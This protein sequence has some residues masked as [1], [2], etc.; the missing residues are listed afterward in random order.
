MNWKSVIIG[1]SV[2]V[3]FSLL[4]L[5]GVFGN[6]EYQIYDFFLRFRPDRYKNREVV[7]LDVDD[8]AIAYN[9][10]FPWPRSVTADGLLRL[11]EYGAQAAIF[12]IEFI[13]KG[14]QGVDTVYLNQGL[15]ADFNRSFSEISSAARDIF[16]ALKSGR[17]RLADIDE[18]ALAFT[19]LVGG[20]QESLFTK[21]QGVARDN[22]QY[23]IQS[24]AL[25]G[26]SWSTLNLRPDELSGEQA[27][28]RF[29]AEERFSYPVKA[30]ENIFKGKNINIL[31]AL[32]GFSMAA[33]GAG[34][35]NVEIDKDGTRRRLYLAQNIH[36]H[37][38]LQLA[39]APLVNYL[40]NPDLEL[41]NHKMIIRNAK[42]PGGT[43]KDITVPLDGSGRMML[44]WPKEDYFESYH[45]ISFV[46]VSILEDIEVELEQYSMAF[47]TVDISFFS[48][49]EQSLR[50]IPII[51]RDL[52]DLFDA[53]REAKARAL[54]LCSD[55]YFADYVNYR[56][57]SRDLIREIL[58]IRPDEIINEMAP[59]LIG[60]YPE[61]AEAI[62]DEA[63]Y[64]EILTRYLRI[65]L[66]RY[67][68]ISERTERVVKDKF[69][70]LGRVDTGTTDIGANPFWG[71]YVNVGTHGVVLDMIL[72]E[73]FVTPVGIQWQILFALIFVF[74]FFL[75]SGKLTPVPRAISGF[76]MI[77]FIVSVTALLFR[78]T[79]VFFDPLVTVM[80]MTGAVI[81]REIISYAGSE[82]EKQFIRKAFSTYVST[83]VVKEL[84]ADPSRLQLG[85]T[86]RHMSA[87]FTD[88]QG[89]STISEQLD[90]EKLVS[91]LNRYLTFM[92]DA[93][94]EQM[95]TIDKYEGDAIIAFFGA[96]VDLP[97][98]A[99]R[100]CE[101]AISM[102]QIEL[103][104]NKKIMEDNLSPSPLLTRIGINTGPMVAGNMGTKNKMDYTIMGNAVNLAA[105]LEGVNKQYGTWI[106]A[107]DD[108]IRET[109][110]RFLTRKLDR[111][112]VVGINE[113]VRIHEVL[114]IM[115]YASPEQNNLVEVF[116]Q[117][118]DFYEKRKWKEAIEGFKESLSIEGAGPS[119][120]YLHRCEHFLA[121]PPPDTWDGVNN[122]TE[123]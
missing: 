99:I 38:Y 86:K 91:L 118:L 123:K 122:L 22:D 3:F 101:S 108:T 12:D 84:L 65:D 82:Q 1:V 110:G 25:F 6:L 95:G 66:D 88:V 100:A 24:S 111:I 109:E 94:L 58:D 28:R 36:N 15:P 9:G 61:S 16:S 73:S 19:G 13:D 34:F 119:K 17:I 115:D 80:S 87:I 62:L 41:D 96:P 120:R 74:L 5:L 49:F 76:L 35:T 59:D 113:P 31:P 53:A 68:E 103:N 2:A 20:E 57:I 44:D 30:A 79:G 67:E 60:A 14:P 11:K 54:E 45:H 39:F 81:L 102:K 89:F 70:I 69:C 85:G 43:I 90:P 98:H 75:A 72:S 114:N 29:M 55:E 4:R 116:Q 47:G 7:F 33:K 46:D 48:Q 71:E 117:A 50:R 77:F 92:S 8:Q 23:L 83:E 18:Y 52:A 26:R 107:S 42:M 63:A 64:I 27:E 10:I 112:R 105:R 93:V 78:F 21:S 121:H 40:G 97:D 37:W 56:S 104:L 51:T 106:L 32:P